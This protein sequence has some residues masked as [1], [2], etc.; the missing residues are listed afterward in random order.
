[1]AGDLFAGRSF[2][3]IYGVLSIG[4]GLGSALG[5]WFAGLLHD[6]TGSYRLAFLFSIACSAVGAACFWATRGGARAARPGAA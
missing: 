1:M 4:N 6:V 3:V 5:P 2:G